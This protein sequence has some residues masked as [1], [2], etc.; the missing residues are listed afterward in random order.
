MGALSDSKARNL[1]SRRSKMKQRG[2]LF[3]RLMK[4]N[5][6]NERRSGVELGIF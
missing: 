3:W 4:K 1:L 5:K 2:N 6:F